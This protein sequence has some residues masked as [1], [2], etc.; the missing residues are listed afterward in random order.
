MTF[1]IFSCWYWWMDWGRS[2]QANVDKLRYR[3]SSAQPLEWQS[4]LA[5]KFNSA[6]SICCIKTVA[7]GEMVQQ[8]ED[9]LCRTL[10]LTNHE[11]DKI[12]TWQVKCSRQTCISPVQFRCMKSGTGGV[13]C[14]TAFFSFFHWRVYSFI[15]GYNIF[16]RFCSKW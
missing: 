12:Y 16:I 4:L 10:N 11:A 7:V 8:T 3:G 13:R 2:G 14:R 15:T 6:M 5:A 1:L 9:I